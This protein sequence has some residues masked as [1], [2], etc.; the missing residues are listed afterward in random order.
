MDEKKDAVTTYNH[1]GSDIESTTRV[2][3]EEP[4]PREG[5]LVRQLKNRH[6]AMIRCVVNKLL[7]APKLTAFT[8]SGVLSELVGFV[9]GS[10]AVTF[11]T[12]SSGLFLGTATA[13]RNGGPIGRWCSL[14]CMACHS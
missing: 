7:N 5:K 14:V 12:V 2:S 6:V 8:V 10:V 4:G 1:N 9:F 11:L 3:K 13:L